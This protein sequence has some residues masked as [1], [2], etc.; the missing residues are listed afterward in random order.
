MDLADK[1]QG[2]FSRSQSLFFTITDEKKREQYS[3]SGIVVDNAGIPLPGAN[4]LE[5]GTRNGTAVR[6]NFLKTNVGDF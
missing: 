3:I 1:G 4:V 2:F 6:P 5:K